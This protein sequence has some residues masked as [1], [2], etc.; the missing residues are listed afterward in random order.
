MEDQSVLVIGGGVAG[1]TAAALLAYEGISV[2]LLEA[3]HQPGGCAGTFRRGSYVFDVGATQ[4]AGFEYGGIHER[5]FRHLGIPL[6]PARILDPGCLID[7]ADG[8]EPI[9]LWHDPQLWK[10]ERR[11]QFPGTELFWV[12]CEQLHKSNW[13]FSQR[14]PVLPIRNS[15]DTGQFFKAL[16]P[17]NLATGC[18]TFFT[19]ADL[20]KITGCNEDL[21]LRKFLDL[22]LKLY[23][24]E[25]SDRTAALYGA[26][27]LQMAQKPLGLW[28]I[29]GSM[30]KLSDRLV[31]GVLS[32]GARLL[33]RNR[34]VGLKADQFREQ[35]IA[36][37]I[38]AKGR[39]V[40][41]QARDVVFSLPPQC[42]LEL[43]VFDELLDNYRQKLEQLPKPTGAIVFYGAIDRSHLPTNCPTHFQFAVKDFS[44]LFLS[45]S[46]D[47]DGRAPLGQA[48]VIASIF[49]EVDEWFSLEDSDYQ[50]YKQVWLSNI[51]DQLNACLGID[52][53]TWL[54]KEL[55]TPKSFAKW[56]GRAKG[57]V[58]G[59]GQH[60]SVFGPFGLP[61]RTP[62]RGLW[63]CGDS[64]F[65]GEG[66]AAV[67]QSAFIATRQ[68]MAERGQIIQVAK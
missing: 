42:L 45:I 25:S 3:H 14:D 50:C 64:I 9:K 38:D 10:E 59:L 66:T 46:C 6:P 24:Q 12:L 29:D 54:H 40:E 61:S 16:R 51:L 35:W 41:F 62:K 11:R 15:W 27:V 43:L 30:Q 32:N 20:L 58:G 39:A 19:V 23:S 31:D 8:S 56:T 65:P 34:V 26:T 22:Q 18:F 57:I 68:L 44:S 1:L 13:E 47:G 21:R 4:V 37:V 55:A 7:L 5:L 33:C 2:T 67:S 48:T 36:N 17:F 49:T 28:H 53:N 63:L 60:P 52:S